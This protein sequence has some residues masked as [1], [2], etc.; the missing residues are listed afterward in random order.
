MPP[1]ANRSIFAKLVTLFALAFVVGVGLC[2]LDFLLSAHGYKSTEEFGVG[3]LDNVSLVVM[4][5]SIVALIVTLIIW[6][7]T[8]ISRAMLKP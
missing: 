3:P 1:W 8:A 7:L 5:L 4:L 2:G 6:A